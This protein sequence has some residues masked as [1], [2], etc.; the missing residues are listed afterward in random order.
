MNGKSFIS[1]GKVIFQLSIAGS[2][3]SHYFLLHYFVSQEFWLGLAQHHFC[4]RYINK[5]HLVTVRWQVGMSGEPKVASV[6]CPA[7]WKGWPKDTPHPWRLRVFPMLLPAEQVAQDSDSKC[8]KRLKRKL[9]C[10]LCPSLR[11]ATKSF[12]LSSLGK[13][14]HYVQ[15]RV[16]KMGHVGWC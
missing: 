13:M 3:Q 11:R 7:S 1:W 16:K 5:S 12:P 14:N 2:K 4:S 9:L 10:L 6:W 8:P 15:V